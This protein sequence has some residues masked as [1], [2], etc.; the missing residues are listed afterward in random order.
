MSMRDDRPDP[1]HT[2]LQVADVLEHADGP[3]K[4]RQVVITM[5]LYDRYAVRSVTTGRL[6][7]VRVSV[8]RS[9][10]YKRVAERSARP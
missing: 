1:E 7:Y 10:R 5:C 2:R 9:K 6:S 3:R 4:G 8:L